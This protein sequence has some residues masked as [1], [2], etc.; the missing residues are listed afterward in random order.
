MP[1][2]ALIKIDASKESPEKSDYYIAQYYRSVRGLFYDLELNEWFVLK[3][4][5]TFGNT[6]PMFWYKEVLVHT[7]EEVKEAYRDAINN[8]DIG[9]EPIYTPD[10]YYNSKFNTK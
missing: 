4:D 5:M 7:E 9:C 10:D 3:D 6:S 1:I 8:L 2:T